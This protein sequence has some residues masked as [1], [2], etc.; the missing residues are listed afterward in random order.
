[1]KAKLAVRH[2]LACQSAQVEAP[3]GVS[4]LY[5]LFGVGHTHAVAGD[6]EFPSVLPELSVFARFVNGTGVAQFEVEVLWLDAPEGTRVVDFFGP[7][8]IT[9]R[10][11]EPLRDTC[12][13]SST[14]RSTARVGTHCG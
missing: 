14:F 5:N 8:Q 11:N 13:A 2:W 12:F 9:F 6:V 4:N 1:M 7:L 3:A 10:P